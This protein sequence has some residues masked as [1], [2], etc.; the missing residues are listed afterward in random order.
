MLGLSMPTDIPWRRLAV[1]EDMI[2]RPGAT[3]PPLWRSSLAIF[4]YE[5]PTEDQP[6]EQ[7]TVSYLKV[8]ASITGFQPDPTETGLADR[9]AFRAFQDPSLV[10]E[11]TRAASA[12]YGCYGALLDVAV[13]PGGTLAQAQQVPL[14]AYPFP[15]WRNTRSPRREWSRRP[16]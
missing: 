9:R 1:S 13:T 14:A 8:V 10:D 2:A 5:P 6:D 7:T 11:F 16:H 3:T 15:P 12:Y 4:G